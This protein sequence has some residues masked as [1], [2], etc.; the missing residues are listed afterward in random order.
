MEEADPNR[1]REVQI[2]RLARMAEI[3]Y[4]NSM[5]QKL[6]M[7]MRESWHQRYTNTVLAL[8][9]LL[10][11][12]QYKDYEKRL[13]ILEESGKTLRRTVWTMKVIKNRMRC[14]RLLPGTKWCPRYLG[15]RDG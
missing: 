3:A 11:D 5:D 4:E 2:Q 12:S 14:T 6:T 13:R 8:N 1:L 15:R 10:K 9:Q 7:K